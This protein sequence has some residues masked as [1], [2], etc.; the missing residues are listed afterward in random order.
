MVWKGRLY[1]DTSL[2]FCLRS[3]PKLFNALADGLSWI[4]SS[5]GMRD[6]LHYLDDFLFIG[7]PDTGEC[8]EALELALT[9]CATLGIPVGKQSRGSKYLLIVS[10]D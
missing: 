2:A 10:R 8:K 5:K 9:T 7:A 3:A 1:V 4:M 6:Q